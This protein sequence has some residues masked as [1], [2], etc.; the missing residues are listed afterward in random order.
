LAVVDALTGRSLLKATPLGTQ[1]GLIAI[2]LKISA[3]VVAIHITAIAMKNAPNSRPIRR[4]SA[5]SDLG[6][7]DCFA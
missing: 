1:I 2:Y 3:I 6:I 4:S 5:P 7:S